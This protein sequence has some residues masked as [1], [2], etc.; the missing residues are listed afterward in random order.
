M[1]KR[2]IA[3]VSAIA[4]AV[5][6]MPMLTVAADGGLYAEVVQNGSFEMDDPLYSWETDGDVK[7]N[8]EKPMNENNPTYVTLGKNSS[9][10]NDGFGGMSVKKGEKYKVSLNI[11]STGFRVKMKLIG[12]DGQVI[13][14]TGK[15]GAVI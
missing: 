15:G 5:A 11:K 14:E 8:T 6:A 3:M 2:L 10:I 1:K 7:V 12:D 4:M 9:I 13:A